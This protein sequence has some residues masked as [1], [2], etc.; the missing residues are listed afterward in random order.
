[1]ERNIRIFSLFNFFSD[2]VFF[3]PVAV[4]YFAHVTGTFAL[5]MSIFS[6]AY[7]S[8]AIFEVPTGIVSDLVGRKIT[9]IIGALFG[10]ICIVFYAIGG[11]YWMLALGALFQGCQRALYS[12][13]NDAYLHDVLSRSGKV[14][15]YHGYLGRTS[16]MFQIALA[17]ASVIGSVIASKSFLIV[18]WLSVI[19]QVL[20][21]IFAMSLKDVERYTMKS[22]NIYA[23]FNKSLTQFRQNY[24]LQLLTTAS[25]IRF[26]LGESSYFLRSAFVNS[27]WPLWAVGISNMLSNIGGAISYYISGKIIDRYKPLRV[28]SFEI[29]FNRIINLISLIFPTVASPALMSTTSLTYGVSSVSMNGLMQKEFTS[30]QRATMSSVASLGGS[31]VFGVC[32]IFLGHIADIF[33][34]RWALIITNIVLIL[35]LLLYRIIFK[36]NQSLHL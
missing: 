24:R 27:L 10:V 19:P 20:S 17:I 30:G 18:M 23:H 4:I 36:H 31:I 6:I 21:L 13:N 16:S 2:L 15:Q 25:V 5:G 26:G 34:A 22:T 12:G 35:P 9:I 1:M 29:V 8:S 32:A 7:V 28:L 14:D 11:S 33:G 3:A